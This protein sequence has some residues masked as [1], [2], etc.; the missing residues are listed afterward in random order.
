MLIFLDGRFNI[1]GRPNENFAR[2]LF[3][4][5]TL[6]KGE[7]KGAGDY[8]NYTEKDIKEAAKV[9]TGWTN[10]STYQNI[11]PD[12]GI[13]VGKVK[14]SDRLANQHDNS[15]KTLT[16]AFST[17][18][19]PIPEIK[20][21][22]ELLNAG[23]ATLESCKDEIS[24]L[25]DIIF[26]KPE[27]ELFLMRK[28]YRFFVH[29]NITQ[30]I[31]DDILMPLAAEFK[32][33]GFRLR[34]ILEKLFKSEFFFEAGGGADDDKFGAIIKSPLDLIFGTLRYFKI[35][36]GI[37]SSEEF[38][39]KMNYIDSLLPGMQFNFLNPYDVAGYEAYHQAPGY[40]RNWIT[41]TS[42]ANRYDFINKLFTNNADKPIKV[43]LYAWVNN[44]ESGIT[45]ELATTGTV[46]GDEVLAKDL[47]KFVASDLLTYTSENTGITEER[48]N[49]FGLY[50]LSGLSF[51]NW[52]YN[53]NSSVTNMSSRDDVR[54]RLNNLYNAL[55]QSPEYQLF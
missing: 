24:Q 54:A 1:Y 30:E 2:E 18:D 49:Y 50:H 17:A 36:I 40:N 55:M 7:T 19:F 11:D 8:T 53:W 27:A 32:T 38:Y 48:Y 29:Y 47:I 22:P 46:V 6:G 20:P 13:P 28:I 15:T 23:R 34:P 37:D 16:N 14:G 52:V 45:N 9:L 31:E 41:T 12:T 43:D 39:Q 25:I 21:K 26:A 42:L 3:E 10:D 4:L 35:D 33:N 44:P 5:F 51:D